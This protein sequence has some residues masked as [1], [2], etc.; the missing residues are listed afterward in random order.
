MHMYDIFIKN[1]IHVWL[2]VRFLV[3]LAARAYEPLH[4]TQEEVVI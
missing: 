2:N 1:W 3:G 4:N